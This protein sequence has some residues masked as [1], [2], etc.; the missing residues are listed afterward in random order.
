LC[1]LALLDAVDAC[2]RRPSA[3]RRSDLRDRRRRPGK[4][5]LDCTVAPVPHPARKP[6]IEGN[7]LYESPV[8]DALNAPADDEMAHDAHPTSP[9]SLAR[10][11][12]QRDGAQRSTERMYGSGNRHSRAASTT[13]GM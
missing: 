12:R 3:T 6:V 11:P 7:I 10:M 13:S 8:P 9:V 1:R 2:A 5:R 4:Y